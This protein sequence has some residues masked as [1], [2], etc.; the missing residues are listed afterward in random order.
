VPHT[1]IDPANMTVNGPQ[2][3]PAGQLFSLDVL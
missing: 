2:D 1:P 3:N